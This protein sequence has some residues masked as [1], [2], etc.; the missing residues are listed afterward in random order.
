[1]TRKMMRPGWALPILVLMV[2]CIVV[3]FSSTASGTTT[4][5]SNTTISLATQSGASG[6]STGSTTSVFTVKAADLGYF[7]TQAPAITSPSAIVENL[8]TGRVLYSKNANKRRPMASTTKIMTAILSLESLPLDQKVTISDEVAR[9]TEE[10]VFLKSGDVLTVRQLLFTMMIHSSN[11]CAV[12]LAETVGGGDV[13]AFVEK[14]NA[15]AKLLGMND[16]NYVNPNGLDTTGHYSTASDMAIL[17]RY[18]M[19]NA[20]FR[21]IVNTRSYTLEIPGHDEPLVFENTNKLLMRADWVNGVKT[22]LTPRANQCLVATGTKNG[23]TILSVILGQPATKV[24][25][26][27]SE[28]LLTYGLAQYRHAT[29]LNADTPVA[30]ATLSAGGQKVRL[31]TSQKLDM[32]LFK[33]DIVAVSVKIDRQLVIPVSAGDKFGTVVLSVNGQQVGS[34]SLV[35]DKSVGKQTLGTKL[36][37]FW[38]RITG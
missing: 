5:L 1:M 13:G 11:S 12:A 6:S 33:E 30:E 32:D 9:T 38:R 14:M 21:Q 29:L 10:K 19:K 27:E 2:V 22:G 8:S 28:S 36:A 25:W 15:K 3:A 31:V 34:V 23:V 26:D 16:T 17:A 24:C 4:T 7:E 20:T 18:A 37:N 35:A